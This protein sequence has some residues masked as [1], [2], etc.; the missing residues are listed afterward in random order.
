MVITAAG[1]GTRHYPATNAV[2]KEMFPLVDRNGVT[3][4]TIQLVVEEALACGIEEMCIITQPGGETAFRAHFQGL[5]EQSSLLEKPAA[6][7]VSCALAEMGARITYV[8]QPSSEGFGHAVF[9]SREWVAG[10][11]FLLLLG[12]H[13]YLSAQPGACGRQMLDSYE[14]FGQAVFG[15]QQTKAERLPLFGAVQGGAL[16][17]KN[18]AIWQ[19]TSVYEK[20]DPEYARRHLQTDTLGPDR[21]LTF[22]GMYIFPP[23]IFTV[24]QEHIEQNLRE[25]G[26]IQLTGAQAELTRRHGAVAVQVD[27]LRLDMGTPL[28]YLETQLLLA[29]H[30]VL[31]DDFLKL[32]VS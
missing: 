20:P 29:K 9:C 12:D 19:V 13:V 23:E 24:L 22:F 26:E 16:L 7:A 4:P 21:F 27:G 30:G 2:Q 14:R 5:P 25:R 6:A 32:F 18:P 8:A 10:E 31:A 1:R 11:P 3:K 17:E 15:V 28:G